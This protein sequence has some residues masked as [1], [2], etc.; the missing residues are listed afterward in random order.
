MMTG[1]TAG[2]YH[3][4]PGGVTELASPFR[5]D[6]ILNG[7]RS[8]MGHS[9]GGLIADAYTDVTTRALRSSGQLAASLPETV[10]G[11]AS[12]KPSRSAVGDGVAAD[13]CRT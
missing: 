5:S 2:Q 11:W 7:L 1:R 8:V 4:D 12:G 3:V 6:A 10:G 13:R 9:T